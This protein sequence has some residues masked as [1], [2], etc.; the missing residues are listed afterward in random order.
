MT[1]FSVMS[2]MVMS[3]YFQ[4]TG[5]SRKMNAERQL[6]ET[7]R[8]VI[9]RIQYD[10]TQ[11]GLSGSA[12][13][14]DNEYD[15]WSSDFDYTGSWRELLNLTNGR[16]VYG[17]KTSLGMDRC[18]SD[19]QQNT[20]KHCGLYFVAYGDNGESGYNLVD[21]FV[22]D[23]SKKRV[24]IEYLRFYVSGDESTT[25][26]KVTLNMK[27][28]LVPKVGISKELAKNSKLHIQTTMTP[29]N[30]QK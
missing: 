3:V 25:G 22:P 13:R 17:Q 5:T 19:I 9:E 21:S 23:D 8:E 14:F 27:I 4:I 11:Y 10:M 29:R 28:A 1:I 18:T 16:Y 26:Y 20:Q 6:A 24:K 7:A 2:I 15:L 12:V 30:W